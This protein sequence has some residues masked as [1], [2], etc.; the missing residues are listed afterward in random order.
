ML[1]PR[2]TSLLTGLYVYGVL[3]R[4]QTQRLYYPTD[5]HGRI[6]RRRLQY[7]VDQ[8]FVNRQQMLYCHPAGGTPASVYFLARLGIEFLASHY[9][10]ERYLASPV[11]PVLPH[12]I[13]HWIAL[14]ETHIAF[15]EAIKT[16]TEVS[17]AGWINEFD[18]VNKEESAPE[19]R[20][21]LYTLLQNSPRLVCNP[22]A[23]FLL[24][25][26]GHKKVFYVE[27][28]RNTSGANHVADSKTR[29]FASMN[30]LKI[31]RRHFRDATVETFTVIMVAPSPKR[32]DILRNAIKDKPGAELWRFT[33]VEDLKP[34]N[35]FVA[36][37]FYPCVGEPASLIKK[38][39]A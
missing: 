21:R 12:L 7:L 22:D 10:D 15:D 23:A 18:V 2:D 14:A 32:R 27:Q 37:I 1:T 4:P 13:P 29:G 25:L 39:E 24:S 35:V 20:Y 31:H 9:D 26:A 3:S 16:Q 30:S 8:K 5:K 6:T 33:T 38:K 28:D 19:K 17:I 34:E 11:L 36:P